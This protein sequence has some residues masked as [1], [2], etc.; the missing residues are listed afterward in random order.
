VAP[1]STKRAKAPATARPRVSG[2]IKEFGK[3]KGY[4]K[5]GN[6]QK[7]FFVFKEVVVPEEFESMK[8]FARKSK[9]QTQLVKGEPVTFEI[10]MFTNETKGEDN[11]VACK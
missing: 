7:I 11:E 3:G 2:T 1:P 9:L 5:Y 8:A 4:I 10:G 6:K